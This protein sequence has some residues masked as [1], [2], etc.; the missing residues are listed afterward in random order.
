MEQEDG[1]LRCRVWDCE[2]LLLVHV[3]DDLISLKYPMEVTVRSQPSMGGK[4]QMNRNYLKTQRTSWVGR[5][6]WVRQ[7]QAEWNLLLTGVKTAFGFAIRSNAL[8]RIN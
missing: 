7:A 2:Y 6:A 3:M 4:L 8:C 5:A 1:F